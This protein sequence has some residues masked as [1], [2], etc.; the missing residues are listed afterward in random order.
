[1]RTGD[2]NPLHAFLTE[3]LDNFDD[4]AAVR[5]F[6][7]DDDHVLPG[8]VADDGIDHHAVVAQALFAACRHGQFQHAGEVGRFLGVTQIRRDDDRVLEGGPPEM[9]CQHLEGIHVIDWHTEEPVHLRRMQRHRQDTV[10]AGRH[11][12]VCDEPGAD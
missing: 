5:D 4:R 9:S 11:E 3:P 10:G 7:V 6:I 12:K 1:M 8:H 2:H